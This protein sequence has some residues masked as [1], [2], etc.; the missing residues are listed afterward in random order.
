M[1]ALQGEFQGFGITYYGGEATFQ[2]TFGKAVGNHTV[3]GKMIACETSSFG[4]FV[5]RNALGGTSAPVRS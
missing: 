4:E 2:A 1:L 5:V 3:T